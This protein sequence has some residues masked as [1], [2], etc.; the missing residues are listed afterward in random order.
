V[1]LRTA[2]Q[3]NTL[4]DPQEDPIWD[5]K[6]EDHEAKNQIL[7]QV[8]KNQGL[9]IVEG[10]DP[11]KTVEELTRIFSIRKARNVGARATWDSFSPTIERKTLD[12]DLP[13]STGTLSG[14][15]SAQVPLRRER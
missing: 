13:G 6:R 14:S 7:C 11:S 1:E 12:A 15:R 2:K 8:T 10:S 3:R 5:H 9:G 4:Q